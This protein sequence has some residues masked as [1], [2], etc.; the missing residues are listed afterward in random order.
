MMCFNL[1]SILD[2][3]S[4]QKSP[5]LLLKPMMNMPNMLIWRNRSQ[6][7]QVWGRGYGGG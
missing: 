1:Y 7:R 3:I 6:H 2:P 4:T 5:F